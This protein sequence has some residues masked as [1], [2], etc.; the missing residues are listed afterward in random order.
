MNDRAGGTLVFSVLCVCVCASACDREQSGNG[1][2][3][4]APAAVT[5]PAQPKEQK[6]Y[7]LSVE[8]YAASFDKNKVEASKK[9]SDGL[10]ELSGVIE[11]V[12]VSYA[13]EPFVHVQARAGPGVKVQCFTAD[14][15]PWAK[16]ARGQTVTVRGKYGELP[17]MANLEKCQVVEAGP[18]TA[19]SL[20]AAGA[21]ADYSKDRAAFA[22]KHRGKDLVVRG[23][24]ADVRPSPTGGTI[25]RLEGNDE[26]RFRCDFGIW[27][28]QLGAVSKL[29][30]GQDVK[31]FGT[32]VTLNPPADAVPLSGCHLITK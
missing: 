19:I 10:V 2:A 24:V 28:T 1:D 7:K 17:T 5:A 31:V 25:V 11:S 18:P 16:L 13:G 3:V 23:K 26:V 9:Y 6:V 8:E 21:V 4:V 22:R 29:E 32:F 14:R 15:E 27:D 12:N 20:T 30:S